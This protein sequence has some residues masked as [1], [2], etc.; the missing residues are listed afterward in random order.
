MNDQSQKSKSSAPVAN[1]PAAP[2]PTSF[3]PPA[4]QWG[5]IVPVRIV[6]F[7]KS[8]DLPGKDGTMALVAKIEPSRPSWSIEYYPSIGFYRIWHTSPQREPVEA[9]V[10]RSKVDS[11]EILR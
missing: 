8:V 3:A 2:R 6:R 5:A 11:F 9:W 1:Q 4:E 10:D 7:T